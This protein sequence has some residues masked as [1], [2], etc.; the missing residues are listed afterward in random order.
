MQLSGKFQF[1]ASR[2]LFLTR[3][4]AFAAMLAAPRFAEALPGALEGEAAGVRPS[5]SDQT[6]ALQRALDQAA[7]QGRPLALGPGLY[8]AA[9]LVLA[10]GAVLVG[11][12]EGTRLE[13]A[14]R[15]P[16]LSARGGK[17]VALRGLRLDGSNFPAGAQAGVIEASDVDE[18]VLDEVAIVDAGGSA[19]A[20]ARTG[21]AVRDCRIENARQAA[22]FSMDGK[23]IAV[24]D[25]SIKGCRNNAVVIRRNEKGDE[26]TVISRNRIE[27]TGAIDGGLGWNGNGVNVS[28]AGGVVVSGNAI[29][30]SAFTAVRAHQADDVM[31]TDNLCLG[32]GEVALFVEYGFSGAVVSSNVVDGSGNGIAVV[33]FNEGGR[34]ATVTGNLVRNL[35][36]RPQ[37]DQ[38]GESYGVGISVEADTAVTGNTIENAPAFGVLAGWGPYLRDVTVSGNVVRGCGVGVGVSVVEGVGPASI[39]GN[40]ITGSKD[41]AVRG[42]RWT[43]ATTPDLTSGGAGRFPGLT[44]AQNT[45]R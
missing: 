12:G 26:P 6:R 9:G 29:R 28:K 45:V 43:E 40:V 23:G 14:G 3:G 24:T 32:C 39:T 36:K 42:Y 7:R 21:G 35:F 31:I 18:L 10:D 2:R 25:C 44:V 1:D 5:E 19:V 22:V 27:D 17:R 8:R 34:L 13:L 16:L 30:R 4:A 33:N 38:P 15:G 11:A 41:G 20:L 37:L